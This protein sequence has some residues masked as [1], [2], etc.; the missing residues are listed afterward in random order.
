MVEITSRIE[1]QLSV[2]STQLP[3]KTKPRR[4]QGNTEGGGVCQVLVANWRPN[5]VLGLREASIGS[6][7]GLI[8]SACAGAWRRRNIF[9]PCVGKNSCCRSDKT[10]SLTFSSPRFRFDGTK[11]HPS[12]QRLSSNIGSGVPA[13]AP[14]GLECNHPFLENTGFTV[15]Q[16]RVVSIHMGSLGSR[17]SD[18]HS[19]ERPARRIL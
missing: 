11:P 15:L 8:T 2:P 13:F 7:N 9:S 6:V 4:A 10:S 14:F 17:A 16:L 19:P 5:C 12:G 18:F 1:N 3:V